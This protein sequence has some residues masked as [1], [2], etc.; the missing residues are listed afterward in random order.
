MSRVPAW[1]VAGRPKPIPASATSK[2]LQQHGLRTVCEAARCPNVGECYARGV[3]TFLL[4][5]PT[6]TRNCRFCAVP[7]GKPHPLE[8]DEPERVAAAAKA[9]G[10]QYVVLTSTTRD[11]L[12]DGGAGFFA[13]TLEVLH[14]RLPQ[15]LVEVLTPDFKGD[16][17]ALETVLAASPAVFNHNV[18]TVPRLYPTVRPQ[19]DFERSLSLLAEA[20]RLNPKLPIKSGLMV[21][22]GETAE[23]LKAVFEALAGAGCEILTLGQYLRPTTRQLPV[24]RYYSPEE[25]EYLAALA[26]ASG[27]PYVVAGPFVRSSYKAAELFEAVASK[28]ETAS[29]E[30]TKL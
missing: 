7:K 18:E 23:E 30:K 13:R 5:G 20:K 21:G 10:L 1:L 2:C 19:A 3:A 11:D 6:C 16:L 12:P 17:R 24:E 15:A 28:R 26:R 8:A 29:Q 27:L 4:M 22:L 9:L 14:E 25:F